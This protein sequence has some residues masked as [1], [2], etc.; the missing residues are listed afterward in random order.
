MGKVILQGYIEVPP[1]AL[2]RVEA[3]LANH[4]LLTRAE[5]GCLVFEVVQASSDPCRFDVY[6]E[7]ADQDSFER[8][9]AR[10]KSST[11]GEVTTDLTRRYEIVI[12]GDP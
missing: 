1:A 10:A 6:E 3:E 9:Q 12:T 2:K 8:H 7:F 5:A 11:W 4:I